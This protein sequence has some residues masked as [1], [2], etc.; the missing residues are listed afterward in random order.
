MTM[1]WLGTVSLWISFLSALYAILGAAYCHRAKNDWLLQSAK[2]AS[3]GSALLVLLASGIL[4][5]ALLS[6][7]FWL[8]YVVDY[9]QRD[10]AW[11]YKLTAFW[12]G[13]AGS[14]LFWLLILSLISLRVSFGL[15]QVLN[16]IRACFLFLLIWIIPPFS[17]LSVPLPD[18]FGLHSML[19]NIGMIIHPPLILLGYALF[20]VPFALAIVSMTQT[21]NIGWEHLARPWLLG[22]WL[23]LT[24]GI[25]T[26]GQWAYTELGW[27][28][29]WA[30]DPVENAS[31]LP[32]LTAT[33]LLHTC[34]IERHGSG[35]KGWNY[36]LV[37]TT[38]LLTVFSTFITRSGIVDSVHAFGQSPIGPYLLAMI[39]LFMGY[40]I[41]LGIHRQ[42]VFTIDGT[43]VTTTR[44]AFLKTSA[45]VLCAISLVV[46]FGTIMP[47]LFQVVTGRTISIQ[48]SFYN[49]A[50]IPLWFVL[51]ASMSLFPLV[52]KL[53]GRSTL[54]AIVGVVIALRLA[55]VEHYIALLA[56]SLVTLGVFGI[57]IDYRVGTR[58]RNRCG[59]H[60]VHLGII[61]IALGITGSVYN[62]EALVFVQ[63]GDFI[64]IEQYQFEFTGLN[65]YRSG[66]HTHVGTSLHVLQGNSSLGRISAEKIFH[67]NYPQPTSR[68]GILS[69]LRADIHLTLT[70]WEQDIT[71]LQINVKPLVA[72]IWLGSYI[73]YLGII[74]LLWKPSLL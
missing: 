31:L 28:G 73:L 24:A 43:N 45:L 68:I 20:S 69:R 74:I 51:L 16:S 1:T 40:S 6:G 27:G 15:H 52:S 56:F 22:A 44:A 37:C 70:G 53:S 23:A 42:K 60:L 54:V 30:W 46:F 26:G 12:A 61:L 21:V 17:Q 50:T 57:I 36:L 48:E 62:Q 34:V 41:Y 19:Q 66:M 38:F 65:P 32:W 11:Y 55:G 35:M 64:E 47:V 18:G 72:W 2:M 7:N 39:L 71:Y 9:T 13:Q 25:I 8:S 33:A 29:Y 14:L 5:H 59:A 49:T 10:L 67:P 3:L 4:W 63:P 58:N